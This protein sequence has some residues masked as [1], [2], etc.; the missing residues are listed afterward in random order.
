[1]SETT[2]GFSLHGCLVTCQYMKGGPAVFV[3][4]LDDVKQHRVR[5]SFPDFINIR[6]FEF[7]YPK[8][9]EVFG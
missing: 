7:G 2:E 3:P 1:M 6:G 9:I 4:W 8:R 5:C